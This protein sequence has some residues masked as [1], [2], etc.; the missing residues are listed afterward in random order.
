M[1]NWQVS[2]KTT[3]GKQTGRRGI[4]EVWQGYER[5]EFYARNNF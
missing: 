2:R 3:A 1:L 4:M 5:L